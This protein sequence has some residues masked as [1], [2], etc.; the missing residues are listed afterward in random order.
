[1]M[2]KFKEYNSIVILTGAGISAESGLKT[3]RDSNGLWENYPVQQVASP[4]GFR[5][6]A[7]L[8]YHFYNLRRAQLLS[9]Q[10]HPNEAH[11]ALGEFEKKFKGDFLLVTQNVDNLHERG[12]SKN[13]IHMHGEL[14]KMRCQKTGEVFFITEDLTKENICQCCQEKGNLRPHIVWFGETPF[15]MIDISQKLSK[16][17][18]FISIGTS[19]EVYPAAMFVEM[20][21]PHCHK[22]ELN[23]E[24]TQGSYKFDE[25][26]YGQASKIIPSFLEG[27]FPNLW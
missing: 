17:D 11:K 4:E 1:M 16:C 18:L 13:L 21:P 7:D 24:P 9:D 5:A 15:S 12:G 2:K 20:V 6:N 3:F 10:V 19:G 22:V 8:V 25:H 23:L 14:L 27:H 26:I